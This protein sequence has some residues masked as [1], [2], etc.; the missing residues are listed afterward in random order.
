M[1]RTARPIIIEAELQ[2]GGT[3]RDL[4]RWVEATR[5]IMKI[6]DRKRIDEEVLPNRPYHFG[7][8]YFDFIASL[9]S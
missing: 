7:R 3:E 5:L 4:S 6:L 9:G 1:S 8:S 2:T